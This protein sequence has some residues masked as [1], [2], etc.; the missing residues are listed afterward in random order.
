MADLLRI[1]MLKVPF[2]YE[3]RRNA[4][5]VIREMGAYPVGHGPGK[6]T[7]EM[8]QAAIDAGYAQRFN[9][10]GKAAETL[11]QEQASEEADAAADTRE[12]DR[13]DQP[14]HVDHD[15]PDDQR[16]DDDAG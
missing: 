2:N 6:V 7:P 5:A 11:R 4:V 13:V 1:K 16:P 10:R 8:A 3:P 12:S 14:D 9:P 15:R